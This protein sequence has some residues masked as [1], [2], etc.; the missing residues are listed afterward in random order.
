MKKN[1]VSLHGIDVYKSTY[2]KEVIKHFKTSF[3]DKKDLGKLKKIP[4]PFW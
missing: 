1:E 3:S 4:T 2:V